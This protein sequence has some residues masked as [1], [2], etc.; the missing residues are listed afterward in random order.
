MAEFTVPIVKRE[1][2][3]LWHDYWGNGTKCSDAAREAMRRGDLGQTID[4]KASNKRQAA[5]E[6]KRL[7]PDCF[8]ISESIS[9]HG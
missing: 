9:R 1:L 8:V 7:R 3:G 6:A 2:L 4:V 5:L